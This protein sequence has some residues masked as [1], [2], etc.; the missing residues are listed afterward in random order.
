[1]TCSGIGTRVDQ[2]DILT[3]LGLANVKNLNHKG[4]KY[5]YKENATVAVR[6]RR[7]VSSIV[8]ELS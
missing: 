8:C 7:D 3:P 6:E 1:M 2:G 4:K 5:K